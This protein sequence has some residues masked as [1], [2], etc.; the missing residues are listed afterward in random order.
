MF[1]VPRYSIAIVF[2]LIYSL[3]LFDRFDINTYLESQKGAFLLL[4]NAFSVLPEELWMSA[5]KL[6]EV[7]VLLPFVAL[8]LFKSIR[9]WVSLVTAALIAGILTKLGKILF[10]VPRPAA[11]LDHDSFHIIGRILSG[12]NSFP[13]GHTTTAFTMLF[14]IVFINAT[15]AEHKNQRALVCLC[16]ITACLTGLSRVALGAHWLGDV[17]L[18]A[19]IG[20]F[21]AYWGVQLTKFFCE[22]KLAAISQR[23]S[24]G[25]FGLMMLI[26]SQILFQSAFDTKIG[27]TTTLF[28]ALVA[29]YLSFNL[30]GAFP[31][32]VALA[33][34]KDSAP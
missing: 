22:K 1:A 12:H 14:I 13:S 11:V 23:C 2:L 16:S 8:A 6:G 26:W 25:L 9:G 3:L 20:I 5:T 15:N 24:A 21:A 19:F 32:K 29:T 27:Y 4:N 18:G 34:P 7:S 33:K 10:A 30:M 28:A 31:K 17:V